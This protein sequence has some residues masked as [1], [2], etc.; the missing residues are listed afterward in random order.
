MNFDRL[1]KF[2]KDG[3]VVLGGQTNRGELYISLSVI[4]NIPENASLMNDEIFGPILPILEFNNVSGTI[5]L[6]N[7]KT[8]PL[9][10]YI[11]SRDKRFQ[12]RIISETSSGGVCI[13]D[14]VVHITAPNLPFGG[15]GNSGF[16]R[17]HGKAGFDT[18]SNPKSVF[19]QTMLFDIPK[20]FPPADERG[21]KILR[22]LLK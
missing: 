21:L 4:E 14:T 19:R 1:N 18:F 9:T 17:Y 2:L 22:Y 11:F 3:K 13:N 12:Q 7:K 20:R 15:V 5:D 10:L 6:I 16:G 8:K